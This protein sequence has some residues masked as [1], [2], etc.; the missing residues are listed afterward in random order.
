MYAL[1]LNDKKLLK[2]TNCI[3][4][5]ISDPWT[6]DGVGSRAKTKLC[7]QK[8]YGSQ[9]PITKIWEKEGLEYEPEEAL[10][11]EKELDTGSFS[12]ANRLKDFIIRNVK[13]AEVMDIELGN[14]S[15]QIECN[16]FCRVGD[17]TYSYDLYDTASNSIRRVKNTKTVSKPDLFRF[18]T[19]F[20]TCLI[21]GL[22]SQIMNQ[23]V[24]DVLDEYS[25]VIDIHDAMI[26]DAEA[27]DYARRSYVDGADE[28]VPSLRWLNKNRNRILSKFLSSIGVEGHKVQEFKDEVMSYVEP[29]GDIAINKWI[30]K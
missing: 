13:T 22:D 12:V 14:E 23:A 27:A 6:V 20:V 26:L 2:R 9:Q 28:N 10:A 29:A 5:S 25:W 4:T 7:M 24:N 1:I 11:L 16:R 19:F 8:M 17:T 3:G 21:H 18:K 15:F 30:M